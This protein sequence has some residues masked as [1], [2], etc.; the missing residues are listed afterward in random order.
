VSTSVWERALGADVESLHPNLR[1]YFAAPPAGSVGRGTGTYDVAGS[2]HRLLRPLLAFLATRS[3]LFPE[4]GTGIPFTVRNDSRVDGRLRGRRTFA[5]P[6]RERV[7]I[8]EMR[9]VEGRVHDFLG[10]RGGLEV[11]LIA[12]VDDAALAVTSRRLWLH[13][14]SL[15]VPLPRVA[16]V[17]LREAWRDGSQHVDVTLS[18]PLLGVWFEYR[19]SFDYRYEQSIG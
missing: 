2:R 16:T 4:Y 8:D 15:R 11:E 3:I 17:R 7:M 9:I 14:R 18:S 13:L 5:F 6:G 1:A 10:G 19:G 12:G